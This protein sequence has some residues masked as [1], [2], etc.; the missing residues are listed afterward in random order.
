MLTMS[1]LTVVSALGNAKQCHAGLEAGM[2]AYELQAQADD[3]A[4]NYRIAPVPSE[5]I[6]AQLELL[7]ALQGRRQRIIAL[8]RSALIEQVQR[9]PEAKKAVPLLL[10]APEK[11][12]EQRTLIDDR[13]L[14]LVY[15]GMEAH[16]DV[17]NSYVFPYGRAALARALDAAQ[18]LLQQGH[19]Q[20][21][22]GGADSF[23]DAESLQYFGE[24]LLS[25]ENSDGF[26]AGEAAVFISLRAAQAGD[27]ACIRAWSAADEKQHRYSPGSEPG[28]VLG[29]VLG[30]L[31]A[32]LSTPAS[33]CFS[34]LNG[35]SWLAK[36]LY[37]AQLRN[38]QSFVPQFE[39]KIPALGLGELGAALGPLSLVLAKAQT[40][41]RAE[42][43]L[44]CLSSDTSARAAVLIGGASAV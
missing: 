10:C 18:M 32:S 36:E 7:A 44:L 43:S 13:Y 22:L 29:Q 27:N 11:L 12:P 8:A 28:P 2:S 6:E 5:L 37:L 41:S 31:S 20:V 24:R 33:A 30:E 34:A 3:E 40:A 9:M 19:E 38:R 39:Q 21:L 15:K 4:N 16:I 42:P 23:I 14:A 25:D 35:E 26:A 17:A 1:E